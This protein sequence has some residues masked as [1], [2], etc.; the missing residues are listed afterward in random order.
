MTKN[1]KKRNWVCIIY[2]ES[3]PKDWRE[4]LQQTGLPC[5][6]SPLHDRD[7]DDDNA[8]IKPH[9][10]VMLA[11]NSPTSYN[12]VKRLTDRLNQPAPKELETLKGYYNYLTHKNAP[13]KAQYDEKDITTI[14]G[15]N[16]ADYVELTRQE[17]LQIKKNIHLLIQEKG[18]TEYSEL[19]DYLLKNDMTSEY[20]I[21]SNNTLFFSRYI[22]SLRHRT[23]RTFPKKEFDKMNETIENLLDDK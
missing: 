20:D 5:A 22:T 16:I 9:Y 13:D 1:V 10:H 19:M 21:A 18:F 7:L 2:P 8:P 15:F 3:A 4:Q 17:V 14:N 12:V 23:L 6:V 11:F